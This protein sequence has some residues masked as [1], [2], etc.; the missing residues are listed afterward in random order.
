MNNRK[1]CLNEFEV[2]KYKN[3]QDSKSYMTITLKEL[4]WASKQ[5]A[6]HKCLELCLTG[7]EKD[8]S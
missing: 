2:L 6:Q 1:K 4:H 8:N 5:K 3:C 7:L